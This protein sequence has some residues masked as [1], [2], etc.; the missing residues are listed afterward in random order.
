MHVLSCLAL[1]SCLAGRE[2]EQPS[3]V[4]GCEHHPLSLDHLAW[5]VQAFIPLFDRFD[6]N[7]AAAVRSPLHPALHLV[8]SNYSII[9]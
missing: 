7:V 5:C 8:A 9:H 1:Q 6:A 3:P 4:A 2:D